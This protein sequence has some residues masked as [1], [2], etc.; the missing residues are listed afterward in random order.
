M[1]LEPIYQKSVLDNGIRV[2]SEEIDHVRSVSIGVWV[3]S[4]SCSESRATNGTAHFL[5]HMLFKGTEKR[6]ALDIAAE[7]DSVGG[8]MNAFTGK[9]WTSYYIK[10]PDY[11]LS[12]AI[13]LLGDILQRSSFQSDEIVKE[14]SVI[15]QEISMLDDSPDEYIHDFFEEVFWKDHPLG[16]PILGT[17]ERILSF[18]RD[19]LLSFFNARYRGDNLVLAAAGHF[20]HDILLDLVGTAFGAMGKETPE[21]IITR[22]QV[23]ARTA[24]IQKDLEQVHMVIGTL[25]PSAIDPKRY[26]CFLLNAVLGGSMSSRLFQEIREKR[27]LA[28]SIHS[29]LAPYGETGLMGIYAG[30]GKDQFRVVVGLIEDALKQLCEESLTE[31]EI[32]AAKE[33]IKGN[34]LLGMEST[35]NRMMRLAKNE[36]VFNQYISP[37]TVI[38]CIEAVE[39]EDIRQLACEMFTPD[40]LSIAA[41]GSVSEEEVSFSRRYS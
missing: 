40:I 3:R 18:K 15:L 8:I 32:H 36:L 22:P 38:G 37:E 5:E 4:G 10:I 17:R 19:D 26:P 20:K 35:D 34:F 25:A 9:E 14:Q 41:I 16:F 30:I 11:H 7:I 24:A 28:Y 27:G 21:A 29:Y 13:D 23:T 31:K 2:V 12:L 39:P 33:M 1:P 6:T